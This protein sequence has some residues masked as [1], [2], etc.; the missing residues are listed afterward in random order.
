MV[1]ALL[2]REC[3]CDMSGV[4]W[5]TKIAVVAAV[6]GKP[7]RRPIIESGLRR[8]CITEESRKGYDG[9]TNLPYIPIIGILYHC[10]RTSAT[11]V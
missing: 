11:I 6:A 9:S 2:F 3:T 10:A 1:K 4:L 8:S 7:H 5:L